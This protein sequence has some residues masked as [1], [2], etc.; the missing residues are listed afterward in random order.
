MTCIVGIA[1]NGRVWLGGDSFMLADGL[2][3]PAESKL[4]RVGDF[5]V[6][7]AGGWRYCQLLAHALELNPPA[8]DAD[9]RKYLVT[10]FTEAVRAAV[11]RFGRMEK[12]ADGAESTGS[13]A[14]IGVRG[15]LYNF[16]GSL[17]YIPIAKG[18]AAIGSGSH[19]A[20]GSLY[21]TEGSDMEPGERLSRALEAAEA[22]TDGVRRPF[23][24]EVL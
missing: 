4:F 3:Y 7:G 16:D 6:G 2:V 22:L 23:T 15:C 21:E 10:D 20:M 19:V 14:L 11:S 12:D 8:P 24:Y 18:F 1:Q 17:S 5:I 13:R 9:I